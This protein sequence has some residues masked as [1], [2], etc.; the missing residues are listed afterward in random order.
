MSAR[1]TFAELR[2]FWRAAYSALD[3]E[4]GDAAGVEAALKEWVSKVLAADSAPPGSP[5]R[6][7]F[8]YKPPEPYFGRWADEGGG[9]ALEGKTVVALINPGDGITYA[10]CANPDISLARRP[11]WQLLKE[12]Y[13]T[14][15]VAC[16]GALHHL[17]YTR[18]LL[19]PDYDY[20]SGTK[21]FGWGWWRGQWE[22]MLRSLGEEDEEEAFVTI[23]LFAYSSP[24]AN[25]LTSE[26]VES[27][28]SSRMAARLIADL[29][30][31]KEAQPR[32]IVLVNKLAIWGPLLGRRGYEFAP[33]G[34]RNRRGAPKAYRAH[35]GG[36]P[37]RVPVVLLHQAQQMKFPTVQGGAGAIFGSP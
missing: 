32:R 9:L 4:S 10:Q 22:N 27:L 11:H 2:K 37:T 8:S 23:E 5:A 15:A 1:S 16:G 36:R 29:I 25:L 34:P 17:P 12:F 19:N 3:V 13:T 26:T 30:E 24:N 6:S 33:V 28:C 18:K 21:L 35:A 7:L 14:G 31:D 20:R